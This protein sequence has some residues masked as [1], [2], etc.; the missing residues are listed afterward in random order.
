VELAEKLSSAYLACDY[1][2]QVR[3]L[4]HLISELTQLSV[5]MTSSKE[6]I[7]ILWR[8]LNVTRTASSVFR[9]YAFLPQAII[10]A[11][12]CREIAEELDDPVAV[13]W[14]AYPRLHALI[15]DGAY[16][17]AHRSG[18]KAASNLDDFR[19]GYALEIYG[20]LVLTSSFAAAA[21]GR[22][23]ESEE[24]INESASV[25]SRVGEAGLR[26]GN[27]GP[28]NVKLHQMA[29]AIENKNYA[30]TIKIAQ[31]V[32]P[33]KIVAK[34]RRSIFWSR[35]ASKVSRSRTAPARRPAVIGSLKNRSGRVS[36]A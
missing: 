23:A 8:L 19:D 11:D 25:A 1:E 17:V 10:A 12:R 32:D 18:V 26:A 20:A 7:E 34:S 35:A 6:C 2:T 31:G 36:S 3:L 13:S 27:F 16:R 21:A 28:N 5:D 15:P 14:S 9:T 29:I 33:K 24:L 4:P 30:D 22:K